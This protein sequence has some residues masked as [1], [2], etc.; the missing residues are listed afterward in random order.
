[1]SAYNVPESSLRTQRARTTL[2]RDCTPNSIKL[3][4]TKEEAI[5]QYILKLDLRGFAP[6]LNT[7]QKM[8]N[9]L[10]VKQWRDLVGINWP[11][12]FIK[13]TLGLKT[14]YNWKLDYQCYK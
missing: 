2:R 11:Y 5:K 8:A 12:S 9:K 1:M 10:L 4:I 13:Y 3:T 6:P 14:K 7:I